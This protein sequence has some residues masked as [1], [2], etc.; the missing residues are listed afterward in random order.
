M[1]RLPKDDKN[2]AQQM[3]VAGVS[4]VLAAFGALGFFLP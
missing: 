2:A 3:A 4:C 1:R